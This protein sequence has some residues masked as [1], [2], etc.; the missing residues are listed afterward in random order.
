MPKCSQQ[1][2]DMCSG[3][4][5]V[6]MLNLWTSTLEDQ[7]QFLA[8]AQSI[9]MLPPGTYVELGGEFYCESR[10]QLLFFKNSAFVADAAI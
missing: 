3:A 1:T 2:N 9:G 4:T 7:L 8:H 6:L 5:P 10:A